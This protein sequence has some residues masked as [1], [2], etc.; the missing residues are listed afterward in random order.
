M[1]AAGLKIEKLDRN[2][3]KEA[4]EARN[5]IRVRRWCRQVGLLNMTNQLDWFEKQHN[6]NS[7]Q[8]FQ[9]SLESG[10]F[11]GVFGLTSIDYINGNGEFSLYV[12][13]NQQKK[14]FAKF[15]L[16]WLLGFGFGELRLNKI[17]GETFDGNPAISLFESLGMKHEG[18]LKQSYFK[19]GRYIDS[20]LFG[21]LAE[22]WLWKDDE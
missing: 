8:M 9:A 14:G 20:H 15:I 1:I 22:D 13:P 3:L 4:M 12:T 21:I 5:D 2:F 11:V 10:Q 7:V 16:N 6:D 19:N 18:T 17:W